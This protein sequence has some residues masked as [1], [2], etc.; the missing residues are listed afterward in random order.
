MEISGNK[1]NCTHQNS[2]DATDDC[3][4]TATGK[5][6]QV[7]LMPVHNNQYPEDRESDHFTDRLI[8]VV[9]LCSTCRL[10][11]QSAFSTLESDARANL[12]LKVVASM[13]FSAGLIGG[14]WFFSL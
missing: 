3:N 4:G 13:A 6:N 9:I 2:A 7:C 12:R 8:R 14:R 10:N 5:T 1:E 11:N